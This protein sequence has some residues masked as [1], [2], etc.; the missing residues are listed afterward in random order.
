[1]QID[2][3]END[4]MD[5]LIVE[6]SPKKVVIFSYCGIQCIFF[7]SWLEGTIVLKKNVKEHSLEDYLLEDDMKLL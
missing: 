1:M 6:V 4:K 5:L 2:S 7:F 3:K